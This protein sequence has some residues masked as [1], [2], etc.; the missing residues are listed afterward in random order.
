MKGS[1]FIF[2]FCIQQCAIVDQQL[3]NIQ[4][5]FERSM[6]KGSCVV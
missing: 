2:V 6:M 5:T 1:A 4:M 3:D